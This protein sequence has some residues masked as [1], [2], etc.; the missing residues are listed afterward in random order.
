MK[1]TLILLMALATAL[2]IAAPA[3]AKKPDD[4]GKPD[5]EP[6]AG[7]TCVSRWWESPELKTSTFSFELTEGGDDFACIDVLT[8]TAGVWE[9]T[10]TPVTAGARV[11][12]MTIVPRDAY[13]PGDS[14][15]GEGRRG[16]D[17]IQAIWTFPHPDDPR[18]DVIPA[19]TVNACSGDDPGGDG[20]FAETVESLDAEGNL[21][22]ETV[23]EPRPWE[24]HPLAFLVSTRRLRGTVE[25]EVTL[26]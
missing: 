18:F 2:A 12:S 7:T 24:P 19:A 20:Q 9:A 5:N 15:G 11:G 10:V 13:A 21:I 17:D 14:C 8:S 3:A 4:A 26:P 25:I 6:L 23:M 16:W 1:K 22:S